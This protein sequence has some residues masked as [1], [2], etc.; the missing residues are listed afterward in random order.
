MCPNEF[1]TCSIVLAWF[2]YLCVHEVARPNDAM[3]GGEEEDALAP[4]GGSAGQE[5]DARIMIA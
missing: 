2:D 4:A 3:C 5:F 1:S